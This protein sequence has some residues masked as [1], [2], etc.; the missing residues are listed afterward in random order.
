MP[1][2]NVVGRTLTIDFQ[3]YTIDYPK[4]NNYPKKKDKTKNDAGESYRALGSSTRFFADL[5]ST[6]KWTSIAG[7]RRYDPYY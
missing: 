2:T 1:A 7:G 5:K 6:T 3:N 4:T